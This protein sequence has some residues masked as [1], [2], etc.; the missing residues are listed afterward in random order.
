MTRWVRSAAIIVLGLLCADLSG[1]DCGQLHLR[2]K[3]PG[4]EAAAREIGDQ[5]DAA[6]GATDCLCCSLSE[7]AVTAVPDAQP[8]S[9]FA[10]HVEPGASAA[11]GIRPVPDRPPCTLAGSFL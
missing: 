1:V 6:P 4:R 11:D 10:R 9:I 5:N 3:D 2:L 8:E 7:E